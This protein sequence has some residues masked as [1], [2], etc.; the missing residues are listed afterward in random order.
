LI[1]R[2]LDALTL[3]D[4]TAISNNFIRVSLASGH[5]MNDGRSMT[6]L[7]AKGVQGMAIPAY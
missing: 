6:E 4:G 5:P 2:E 3:D 1:G 7:D